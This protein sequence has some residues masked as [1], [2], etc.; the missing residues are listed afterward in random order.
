MRLLTMPGAWHHPVLD[1]APRP[2]P[3]HPLPRQEEAEKVK[4]RQE[5]RE[6]EREAMQAELEM[7]QRER[8]AAEAVELERKQEEFLLEQSK[9]RSASRLREGRPRAV[10]ALAALVYD[11]PDVDP[12]ELD[13]GALLYGPGATLGMLRELQADAA[14]FQELDRVDQGRAAFWAALE[15]VVGAG[16]AEA[17][18][19]EEIDQ[20]K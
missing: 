16:L 14:T 12:A 5:Q 6:A 13:P 9:V 20:A 3:R 8:A 1:L 2:I 17:Q 4:K 18:R 11:L 15:T 7:I 10:D 19:E